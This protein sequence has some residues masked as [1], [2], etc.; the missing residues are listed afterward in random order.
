MNAPLRIVTHPFSVRTKAVPSR[1]VAAV[2]AI[3]VTTVGI[4]AAHSANVITGL[5]VPLLRNHLESRRVAIDSTLTIMSAPS[6]KTKVRDC[7]P[8]MTKERG[9]WVVGR[10]PS[11][12]ADVALRPLFSHD[13][14]RKQPVAASMQR[15]F[16][17]SNV[18]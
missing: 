18:R 16:G 12:G 11:V 5:T 14:P 7:G 17:V 1:S 9:C 15:G 6:K 10:R 2:V 4:F 3:R 13:W 8:I